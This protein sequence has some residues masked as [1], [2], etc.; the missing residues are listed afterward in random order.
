[1]NTE[2]GHQQN[3]T[4]NLK[5]KYDNWNTTEKNEPLQQ[6]GHQGPDGRSPRLRIIY[7]ARKCHNKQWNRTPT[8]RQLK[9]NWNEHWNGTPTER[10]NEVKTK[11]W[12]INEHWNGTSTKWYNEMGH[13][14]NDTLKLKLKYYNWNWTEMNTEM[15]H[16]QN[17][18]LNLKL[19]YNN[20]N[21]TER[22]EPLQQSGHQGPD[23]RS[24]RL[25]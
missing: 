20:W 15:G 21:T 19:K 24:P 3:D 14:P 6:S 22:N 7:P 10:Y 4:L 1:M 25:L 17:D 13:Q 11:I 2:M 9:G 5:L 18:T 8:E 12:Q 16:Q 23:G